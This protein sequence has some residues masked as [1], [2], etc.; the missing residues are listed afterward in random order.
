M[1]PSVNQSFLSSNPIDFFD[2]RSGLS[3]DEQ[4]VQ[5]SVGRFVDDSVLPAIRKYFEQHTFSR[6]L[7]E[8]LADLGLL[9]SSLAG[10]GCAGMNASRTA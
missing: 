2:V 9:G 7:V 8:G 10:Y 1:T 6:E 4:M 5:D 3:E